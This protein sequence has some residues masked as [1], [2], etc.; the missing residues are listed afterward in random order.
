MW[1]LF[2][3][4]FSFGGGVL[5]DQTVINPAKHDVK[6]ITCDR[7]FAAEKCPANSVQKH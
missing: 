5:V 7:N 3:I 6:P 2:V 1:V 4:F